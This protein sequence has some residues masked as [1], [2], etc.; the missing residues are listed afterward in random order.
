MKAMQMRAFLKSSKFMPD[1]VSEF[2]FRGTRFRNTSPT[3]IAVSRAVDL[4][5]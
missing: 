1:S 4:R 5:L 2:K 3:W